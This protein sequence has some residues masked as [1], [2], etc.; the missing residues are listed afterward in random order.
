MPTVVT[1]DQI[2]ARCG[3]SCATVSFALRGRPGVSAKV[4]ARIVATARQMGYRPNPLVAAHMAHVRSK[5][6]S[7]Y[8][9]TIALLVFTA[10]GR[11]ARRLVLNR[12]HQ[13]GA[14]ARARQL[15]Y[16]VECIQLAH[17]SDL[18]PALARSLK[19]RGI[20]GLLIGQLDQVNAT[21]PFAWEDFA[22]VAIGYS[23]IQPNLNRASYDN[24]NGMAEILGRLQALGYRRPGFAIDSAS[25]ARS[26]HYSQASFLSWHL[27]AGKRAIPP[28][29][30]PDWDQDSFA[31]WLRRHRPDVVI[32]PDPVVHDWLADLDLRAPQDVGVAAS[33]RLP[34][35]PFTGMDQRPEDVAAAAV[36]LL[37]ADLISNDRG[38]P[39]RPRL[40]FVPGTWADGPTTRPQSVPVT[41]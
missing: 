34:R 36:D 20:T 1:L 5:H 15:G 41:G 28:L 27:V 38:I 8:Q 4:R 40:V 19:H 11:D 21:V 37:V 24:F 30:T 23:L 29:V 33:F 9:A 25:D 7:P 13:S 18:T 16:T 14:T 31:R 39:E 6:G 26:H 2:A 3:V 10:D 35:E 32:T 12:L 22:A 17:S